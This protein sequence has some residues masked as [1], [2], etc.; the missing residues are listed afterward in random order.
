MSSALALETSSQFSRRRRLFYSIILLLFLGFLTFPFYVDTTAT[1]APEAKGGVVSFAAWGP[2]DRP[3]SL[4]GDW[5]I[6]WRAPGPPR[7]ALVRVPGSW[8]SPKGTANSVFPPQGRALYR[9]T[10]KGLEA[11]PYH[12]FIPTK[13]S[14]TDIWMNGRLL[15]RDGIVGS[16]A[17]TTTYRAGA[18]NLLFNSTG[19]DIELAIE[20]ASFHHRENGLV[21]APVI[22]R[23]KPMQYLVALY[24]A[25]DFLFHAALIML[26]IFS[27]G[28]F[29]FRRSDRASL[30]LAIS[31]ILFL[32]PAA[33]IGYNNL[34]IMMFPWLDFETM[35]A[36]HY[37][38]TIA[39]LGF[40]LAYAHVLF[41]AESP[42]PIYRIIQTAMVIQF[43]IQLAAFPIGGSLL[44]SYV[45][46]GLLILLIINIIYV[47]TLLIR[48]TIR[49]RDGAVIFLFGMSIFFISMIML[50]LVNYSLV[51]SDRIAGINF[52]GYGIL[53]LVF[54]HII[55]LAERWSAA[56]Y[57]AEQ[58]TEDLRQ[59]LD[60]NLAITSEMQLEALLGKIVEV[61]SKILH[62]DRASLFI[63]DDKR[64]ELWS[65]VAQGV[66]SVPIRFP[67]DQGLAGHALLSGEV[68]NIDDAYEDPRFIKEMDIE[69]GYRS[70]SILSVPIVARDGRKLGVMQALNRRH[71]TRF[72]NEDIGKMSAFAA[73]A[74]IAIDNATM[75]AQIVESRNYNESI[76]RSM[77][78]GVLT[79]DREGQII[80][81]NEAAAA[82]F[83]VTAAEAQA[84]NLRA[85]LTEANPRSIL[86]IDE[87]SR[88]GES[89][90]FLDIDLTT[91]TGGTLSANVSIVPLINDGE[92]QGLLILIE[93]ITQGKRLEGAMRRFMTQNV[94]DQVLQREDDLLFGAACKVSVM[95]ADIRNFTAMAE[96]LSPRAALDMLNEIF[97]ELFEAVAAFDG[98]L[99]KFIGDALMAV[100]GAPIP[101][102]RDAANAVASA[103]Q[104]QG[105]MAKINAQR[106]ARGLDAIRLGIGIASGD[107]IAG[108]IGSPKRMD[109]TVVGDSVNL[110]ARLENSTKYYQV[111]IIACEKTVAELDAGVLRR[112]LDL[113]RV[114][115][116]QTP[117]TI[118]QIIPPTDADPARVAAL[119]AAYDEGRRRLA[120]RD[121]TG[122]QAAFGE[123]L[124]ID[125][126]DHP[127]QIMSDRARILMAS[128]PEADWD[129]VWQSRRAIERRRSQ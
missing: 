121:W 42:K 9:L 81:V 117:S 3:V 101:G 102:P 128:P 19:G 64:H 98:M 40:F 74:A 111:D 38:S 59:L 26:G 32:T 122:A 45:N 16:T 24:W 36:A 112:E 95:F 87:V 15:A 10:I 12:L 53:V 5:R 20:M 68:V 31:S 118:Y 79:V 22:G 97:T 100:Y 66:S 13:Y 89:K 105:L 14:A 92:W 29:L 39:S 76:L 90:T 73:Q 41:P 49:N 55:V 94:V 25:Q 126:S 52:T 71:A 115:G 21:E 7:Q 8:E 96:R 72:S 67:A 50:T 99:D 127:S 54:S 18:V 113:I 129:G 123:A 34:L 77:S 93:D 82:M 47:M 2:L 125:P 103:V 60:V 62:A 51:P 4:T 28:V 44:A 110:A 124:A 33:V 46:F 88:S 108:T 57:E 30:Y 107:V 114:R 58:M 70:R 104:M 23:I 120:T 109:Y 116:R 91:L 48:A 69:T 119:I 83:G 78:A 106:Q 11:G 61:T 56:I 85:F 6:D 43:V 1:E 35:L 65:L 80:K 84:T 75:F 63:Y 37:A 86:E 27:L 17:A